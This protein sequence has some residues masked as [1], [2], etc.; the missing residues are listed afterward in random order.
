MPAA[1]ESPRSFAVSNA[2][3]A[4]DLRAVTYARSPVSES[5]SRTGWQPAGTRATTAFDGS[6]RARS[7]STTITAPLGSLGVVCEGSAPSRTHSAGQPQLFGAAWLVV[8]RVRSSG[9]NVS[10]T[11]ARPT[12]I[13]PTIASAL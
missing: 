8:K 3:S 9:E 7:T 13:F 4:F 2:S 11:G 1:V 10:A 5:T 12:G 6:R